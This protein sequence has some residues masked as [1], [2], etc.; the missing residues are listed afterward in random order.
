MYCSIPT[1]VVEI[2]ADV[3]DVNCLLVIWCDSMVPVRCHFHLERRK[4]PNKPKCGNL[5]RPQKGKQKQIEKE[6]MIKRM[7]K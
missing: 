6:K 3:N 4:N 5:V 7:T 2:Y 1:I